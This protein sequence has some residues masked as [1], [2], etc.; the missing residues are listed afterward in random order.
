MIQIYCTE[1]TRWVGEASHA[2]EYVGKFKDR[3]ERRTVPEPRDTYLC[4]SCGWV[5]V[6]RPKPELAMQL[7]TG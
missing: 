4:K 3:K 7:K 6:F 1:C 5:M 2:L